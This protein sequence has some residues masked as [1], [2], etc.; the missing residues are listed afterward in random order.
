MH[1]SQTPE[2]NWLGLTGITYHVER[3]D[4][5]VVRALAVGDTSWLRDVI[6]KPLVTHAVAAGSARRASV[7][8]YGAM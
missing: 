2:R 8:T 4:L 1:H 5:R 6:T 7:G 3:E